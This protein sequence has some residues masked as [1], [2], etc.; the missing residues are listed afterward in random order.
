MIFQSPFGGFK[1]CSLGGGQSVRR[2]QPLAFGPRSDRAQ[3]L[4]VKEIGGA[5]GLTCSG[6]RVTY[7][8][9]SR[10]QCFLDQKQVNLSMFHFTV[11]CRRVTSFVSQINKGNDLGRVCF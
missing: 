3:T 1:P 6:I 10:G 9:L 4:R 11:L 2:G 7:I 5:D 8:L